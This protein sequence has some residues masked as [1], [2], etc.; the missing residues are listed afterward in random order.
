MTKLTSLHCS[1][2]EALNEVDRL[3]GWTWT[4][5][6]AR[7][8]GS[9]GRLRSPGARIASRRWIAVAGGWC[10]YQIWPTSPMREGASFGNPVAGGWPRI[11][12]DEVCRCSAATRR[13]II[14]CL[15][16]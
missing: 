2:P 15:V 4:L 5:Q 13:A 10:F 6:G 8:V 11:D 12:V 16:I 1:P 9:D 14:D 3:L 7:F